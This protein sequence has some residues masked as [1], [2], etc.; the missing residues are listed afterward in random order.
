LKKEID[1]MKRFIFLLFISFILMNCTSKNNE[2]KIIK[3][4][5]YELK[6]A[7]NQQAIL[8][9]FPCFS[10]DITH[11]TTEA[12]FLK[13]IEQKGISTLILNYNQKLFLTSTEMNEI[14]Q[15]LNNIFEQYQLSKENIIFG[16][17]SSGGNIAL[18]SANHFIKEGQSIQ[19]NGLFVVDSPL[20]LEELYKSAQK[21]IKENINQDAVNE[22]NFLVNLF[23]Q[24][25]GN[26]AD[27]IQNYQEFSP[28][29]ISSNSTRNIEYL[30]K[31]N[32]RFYSEPDLDWQ[33]ENR[34][35]T[36]EDLNA[37]KLEKTT[38]ALKKLGS[39]NIEFIIT[40]QRGIRA[41][42]EKHPHSWNL[43]EQKS[44]IDWIL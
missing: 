15:L 18:L 6:I 35:R 12:F 19:P 14:Q 2:I 33:K 44:L 42:G 21:D 39:K 1:K 43:V 7:P 11:T 29:L 30:T 40:Q 16:G 34:N 36:Y 32:I 3:N 22:G 41:N 17:F 5:D 37:Y 24:T 28:Y 38:K 23:N 20:D 8:V 26:P 25:L 9:L 31:I 13:N 27:S 10:C 4:S